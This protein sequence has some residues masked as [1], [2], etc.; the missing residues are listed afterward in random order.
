MNSY[1]LLKDLH[2]TLEDIQSLRFV[3]YYSEHGIEKFYD[4]HTE[5]PT[6]I[7]FALFGEPISEN[8]EKVTVYNLNHDT[9]NQSMFFFKLV[10]PH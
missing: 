4:F 6:L 5:N 1:I 2:L 8:N 10:F 9:E 3:C 7:H